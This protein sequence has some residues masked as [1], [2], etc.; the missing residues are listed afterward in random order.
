MKLFKIALTFCATAIALGL[1]ASSALAAHDPCKVLPAK[2]FGQIMG[3]TATV[4]RN[5]TTQTVCYYTGP[6]ENFGRFQI[7]TEQSTPQRAAM[8]VNRRGPGSSP[9]AG[10]GQLGGTYSQGNI[11][12]FVSIQSTSQ[13]KLQSVV[14]EIKRN[15]H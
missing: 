3:Y 6:G 14:S 13:S 11:V 4:D 8:M 7:L 12:F 9:P 2:K 5:A 15:L 1:M 10:S